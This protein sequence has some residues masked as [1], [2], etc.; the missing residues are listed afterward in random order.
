[1]NKMNQQLMLEECVAYFKARPVYRKLFLKM[2]DKYAG[3][4]H[5]GGTVT[6]VGLSREEKTQ[7]SGFFQKDYTVNKTITISAKLME[8][9]LESSK[10]SELDWKMILEAYFG[11]RLEVKKDVER[12][13]N[14]KREAYFTEMTRGVSCQEGSAWLE[15]VLVEKREGYLL[16]MQLYKE[17]PEMLSGIVKYVMSGIEELKNFQR[18]GRKELMPVFAAKVTGNPHYFDEGQLGEKLLFSYLRDWMPNVGSDALSR[19]E[20]KNRVWYEAGIL[21]DEVSNDVLAYGIH[22]WRRGGQIHEGIEGFLRNREPV[23]L[24]LQTI[25]N[26]EKI[27]GQSRRV[28]VVENP[29]VFSVLVREHPEWT[30]ICGN[31]QLR[32]AAFVLMDKFAEESSFLY[33]GDFDPEGL[34][35]AQR[36]KVR[37][38]EKLE[39]WNYDV[40][41]YEKY[42]SEVQLN[43]RRMKKLEQIQIEE[44]RGVKDMMCKK[45]RAAYQEAML[46]ELIG[47]V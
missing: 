19:V 45:R 39:L 37:Y 20:Y 42:L 4:G 8:R 27:C 26:L 21:K 5:F 36:L 38:K 7:L 18:E 47:N 33:A 25:G 29:A 12:A 44:L 17:N 35:I 14:E 22:G 40:G 28:Y 31:G 9:C 34:L 43:E 2:R 41:L 23:K 15:K 16:F 46:G 1:M 32:L 6:L 10:F 3:L 13:E 24:T 11:K 30:V